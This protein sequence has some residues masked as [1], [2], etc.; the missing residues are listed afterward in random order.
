MKSILIIL[1]TI[2]VYSC[3]SDYLPNEK[4]LAFKK[5]MTI[6]DAKA[7]LQLRIW[8]V[9]DPQGICGARG[10]WFDNNSKMQV[11]EDRI[12]MLAHKRGDVL[13]KHPAKIG[14]VVVFEKSYYEYDFQFSL[15]KVINVFDD[16]LLL[17]AFPYC[18]RKEMTGSYFI[19]DLFGDD[20]NSLK[21]IVPAD[22]FDKT[23]AALS[24]M[25]KDIPVRLK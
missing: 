20:L 16:P 12:S 23:M 6:D 11:L 18:N 13:R 24:I 17:P 10:F 5:N 21:F 15:V 25:F 2:F 22:E 14:E 8:D 1:L 9:E 4:M 7:V 3:S 19:I